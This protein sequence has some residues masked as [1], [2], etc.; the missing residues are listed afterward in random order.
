MRPYIAAALCLSLTA[1]AGLARLS[2]YGSRMA[3]AQVHVGRAGFNIW[4]HPSDPTI[5]V[6][7]RFGGAIAGGFVEGLTL[8]AADASPPFAIP[9][10]AGAAYLARFGCP[11]DDVWPLESITTEIRYACPAGVTLARIDA[12]PLCASGSPYATD[13]REPDSLTLEDCPTD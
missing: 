6:Q 4:I 1:C 13:W 12:R 10:H 3:D 5:I 8:G 9:R 11:S 7:E 2:S